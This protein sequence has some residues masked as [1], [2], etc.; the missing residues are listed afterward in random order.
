MERESS[1]IIRKLQWGIIPQLPS[2]VVQVGGRIANDENLIIS[3]IIEDKNTF[4]EFGNFEYIIYVSKKGN[5]K[6]QFMWKRFVKPP[7]AIE[8]FN[9]VNIEERLV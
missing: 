3:D 8:Y 6:E 9:P 1:G 2:L 4:F 7:D 5:T